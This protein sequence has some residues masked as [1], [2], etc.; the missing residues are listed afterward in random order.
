MDIRFHNAVREVTGSMHLL[1]VAGR[2]I[3]LDCGL[4]QGKRDA[5]DRKNRQFPFDP[6]SI[7]ALVLSHAHIDHSGNIPQLAKQ[8]FRGPVYCTHATHDLAMIMLRDSAH[9]QK[10]DA[11]FLA[12]RSKRGGSPPM[13]PLYTME[14]AERSLRQFVGMGYERTFLVTPEVRATFFDAGHILGSAIVQIDA[15]EN[16]RASRIVFTGDLGRTNLPLIQDPIRLHEADVY[17][18]ESTYGNKLHDDI[19]GMQEKLRDVVKRTIDR[20]GKI[21]VPA[22][23]V[24]RTQEMV[25]FL[26][27]L[28]NEGS[29]P[30]VP[31]YVDSPLSV[32]ATEVFRMH[33]ELFDEE[34]KEAFLDR[35]EDPFGFRR[36]RYIQTAD[37]SKKL[38][39]LAESCVIISA[40]GMCET[41]RILHHLAN[42]VTDPK[43][44]VLVVS[45]MAENT[46]GR[47]IVE[48][49]P[50]LRILGETVPLRAEVAV[51]NGFSA[52]ADRNELL[53]YFDGLDRNRLKRVFVVHG[54]TAQSE[55][56]ASALKD[57]GVKD[58][59][60]PVEG[61]KNELPV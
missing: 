51:L 20:K 38:N 46:L 17:I 37:E 27:R 4:V 6:K 3:L 61:E 40:S 54:E 12:R 18:T 8:G 42:N 31:I 25:Y 30:E 15:S 13:P 53:A 49:Q 43:N 60:I 48:K 24:G 23:S 2:R 50:I 56:L 11:E 26:H 28:I 29:L 10:K 16:G 35:H 33:A 1:T 7:D 41:G 14:D 39:G 47:R 45:F 9:I 36:L 44:T 58:V 32:N 55:A 22:F 5:A 52:H 59:A 21:I 19:R 34:T 57:R